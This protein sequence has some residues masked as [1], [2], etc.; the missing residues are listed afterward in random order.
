M[1]EFSKKEKFERNYVTRMLET[2][3]SKS[4][5][6]LPVAGF[7]FLPQAIAEEIERR[8]EVIYSENQDNFTF[9]F[10]IWNYCTK[11][12]SS[13]IMVNKSLSFS[14]NVWVGLLNF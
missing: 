6:V 12:S 2:I 13:V 7:G 10:L 5:E 1:S 14:F 11:T 9:F 8:A 4:N 3:D